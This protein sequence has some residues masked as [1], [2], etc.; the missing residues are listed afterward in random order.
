MDI[1]QKQTDLLHCLFLLDSV[2]AGFLSAILFSVISQ[3]ASTNIHSLTYNAA[4][5]VCIS[6]T[7]ASLYFIGAP[8]FGSIS[9]QIGRKKILLFCYILKLLCL[10]G[11]LISTQHKCSVLFLIASSING[12]ANCSFLIIFAVFMDYFKYKLLAKNLARLL[13]M[14]FIYLT[15]CQFT[16]C[17]MIYEN[18]ALF[19]I[20]IFIDI[21]ILITFIEFVLVICLTESI[22]RIAHEIDFTV[23]F[24]QIY[25]IIFTPKLIKLFFTLNIVQFSWILS[26]QGLLNYCYL[27]KHINFLTVSNL[28]FD[29]NV[30]ACIATMLLYPIALRILRLSTIIYWS[31]S[32]ALIAQILLIISSHVWLI[33]LWIALF[34]ICMCFILPTMW[35]LISQKNVKNNGVVSSFLSL[36]WILTWV[37]SIYMN[38]FLNIYSENYSIYISTTLLATCW[39]MNI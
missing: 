19:L 10:I 22:N 4:Y 1:I 27:D 28:I 3:G 32:C 21:C 26:Y 34:N 7:L 20:K 18:N 17:F 39:A 9:G 38:N 12:L 16:L 33:G 35:L 31:L 29:Q 8:F 15:I 11:F 24:S 5:A 2:T 30:I 25:Q 14:F 37:L 23:V 13:G 36:S 6:I